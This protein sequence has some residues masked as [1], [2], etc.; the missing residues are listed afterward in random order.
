MYSVSM[1]SPDVSFCSFDGDIFTACQKLRGADFWA[2]IQKPFDRKYL[3]N[4]GSVTR[5]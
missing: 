4:G 3:K 5:Q 2:L 1:M